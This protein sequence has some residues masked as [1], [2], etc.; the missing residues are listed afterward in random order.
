MVPPQFQIPSRGGQVS[1]A[2]WSRRGESIALASCHEQ[3]TPTGLPHRPAKL[4]TAKLHTAKLHRWNPC[5]IVEI[6]GI[7]FPQPSLDPS[8][9]E[10]YGRWTKPLA[11]RTLPRGIIWQGNCHVG[12]ELS[13]A[14]D[15]ADQPASSTT[16]AFSSTNPIENPI[17]NCPAKFRAAS[18]SARYR[19]CLGP[20]LPSIL[21]LLPPR[22]F[23]TTIA[24]Y[25]T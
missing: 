14:N 18:S 17:S 5:R 24:R 11:R 15:D 6:S 9:A 20:T 13:A 22:Q 7:F 21:R 8:I 19:N 1:S 4:H 25:R 16:S 3:Y 12:D 23:R 10:A 2:G